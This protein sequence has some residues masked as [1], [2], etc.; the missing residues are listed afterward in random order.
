MRFP[1]LAYPGSANEQPSPGESPME[2]VDLQFVRLVHGSQPFYGVRPLNLSLILWFVS[3][4]LAPVFCRWYGVYL[5]FS[6]AWMDR[7]AVS[8]TGR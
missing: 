5:V 6:I 2:T 8:L 7:S 3:G 1:G 4:R